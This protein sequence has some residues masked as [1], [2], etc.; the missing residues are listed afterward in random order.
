MCGSCAKSSSCS[1]WRRCRRR[2]DSASAAPSKYVTDAAGVLDDER[3]NA[4]NER[5]AQ[6]ERDTTNQVI[7]YVDRRV[8][9]GT[10]HRGD[11]RRGDPHVDSRRGEEGQRRDPASSSSTTASR[12]SRSATVSK[13]RSP[14]RRR[15]ASSSTCGRSCASAITSA[16]SSRASRR[17]STTIAARRRSRRRP[18]RRLRRPRRQARFRSRH[19]RVVR[20]APAHHHHRAREGQRLVAFIR[21]GRR[22]DDSPSDSLVFVF[23]LRRRPRTRRRPL[24]R[25][26]LLLRPPRHRLPISRAAEEAEEEAAR[27]TSGNYSYRSASTGLSRAARMLGMIVAKNDTAIENAGDH[28]EVDAAASRTESTT[29][30]TPRRS[31]AGTRSARSA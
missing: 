10:T 15:S 23:F 17:S 16:R 29:R 31:P 8:P 1:P 21:T 24:L 11:G 27:A 2:S 3:E 9:A 22:P 26:R 25:P 20:P 18:W 7:V 12:A 5:L 30:N 6:Y 14:T 13:A 19:R 28:R 4:L